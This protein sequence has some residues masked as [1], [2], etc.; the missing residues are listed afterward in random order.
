MAE[1]NEPH[2]YTYP[3][4]S[5]DPDQTD[6]LRNKFGLKSHEALA[7]AEYRLTNNRRAELAL[8]EGP[9][10]A[11][12]AAHLKAIHRHLF[13]QVYEWA[14]YTRNERPIVDGAPVQ[15]IGHFGKDGTAFLHGSRIDMGLEEALRPIRNPDSL[16]T[17]TLAAFAAI[18]SRV[19]ADL[20][21]VHPFREGNGRTQEAFIAALGRYVGHEVDFAVITRPRMISASRDAV[22][23]PASPALR[24]LVEDAVDPGRGRAL[25]QAFAH[26]R[27]A[28]KNPYLHHVSTAMVGETVTGSV[29]GRGADSVSL[30]TRNGIVAVPTVDISP[31][32]L[33][34]E[35]VIT[36]NV[37][38]AFPARS[39]ERSA[40]R[41]A[42]ATDQARAYWQRAAESG[43]M[44]RQSERQGRDAEGQGAYESRSYRGAPYKAR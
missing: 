39:G 40:T 25:R 31:P 21:Y 3:N 14:G 11:F 38:S 12:D 13:S 1:D 22:A 41:P 8:G 44:I 6:V 23:Y 26:L 37:Q 28:G 32:Q 43:S 10:G 29:F 33:A 30:V 19:L 15:P 20:N 35:G 5:D 34:R 16:R 17:T 7:R 42:D 18:A 2:G 4:T 24:H 27:E 36:V 9:I